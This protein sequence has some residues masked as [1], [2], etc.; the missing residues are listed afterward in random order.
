MG[1]FDSKKSNKPAEAPALEQAATS[2]TGVTVVSN[3]PNVPGVGQPEVMAANPAMA[4]PGVIS[5]GEISAQVTAGANTQVMDNTTLV[6]PE[7]NYN[8]T[9]PGS[10]GSMQPEYN[11]V[12]PAGGLSQPST[13]EA[14]NVIPEGGEKAKV[15]RPMNAYKYTIINGVGKKETGYFDAE[16]LDDVRNFLTSLNYQVL[17]VKPRSAMDV[18]IGGTRL[19]ANDL[20]FSLTQ[21]STYLKA[22]ISLADSVRILAK[23]SRKPG[24]KKSFYQLVYELLRGESLS[25]AMIK[26][27][28]VYP[29]LLIN[30]IK[31]AEMTGDLPSILDDMSEYYTS[32]DQK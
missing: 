29:K 25:E 24:I 10:A 12:P 20:S 6:S 13:D 27:N 32:M 1:L 17:D 16:S 8:N 22:G 11:N 9:I 4:D 18:E 21:L 28:K 30:M 26:Q 15:D 14:G 5:A 3:N 7:V 19:K 31:T 2:N 23:Q